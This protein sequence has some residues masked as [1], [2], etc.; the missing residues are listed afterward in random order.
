MAF[1]MASELKGK[2]YG[3]SLFV[4]ALILIVLYTAVLFGNYFFP[5]IVVFEV[6]G[7]NVLNYELWLLFSVW[8][9]IMLICALF[10]WLGFLLLIK[11]LLNKT[12]RKR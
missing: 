9:I 8:L 11:P 1:I 4:G 12:E 2:I 7:I 3:V 6:S 5:D 10:V